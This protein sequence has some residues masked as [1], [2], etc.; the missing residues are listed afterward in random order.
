M[1]S[2]RKLCFLLACPFLFLS[3]LKPVE[4]GR[5][6]LFVPAKLGQVRVFHDVDGF[7]V[8]KN[9][10]ISDIQNCFVDKEIRNIS[11]EDLAFALGLKA[12]IEIGGEEQIFTRIPAELI[13]KLIVEN[14]DFV[15]LSQEDSE[16]IIA[17]L[18]ASGYLHVFQFSDG[19]Y[20]LHF[21]TRL[22]GGGICGG[23]AGALF[24]KG[25]VHVIG[26]GSIY[27]VCRGIDIFLPGAGVAAQIAITAIAAPMIEAAS[28]KAA[29]VGGIAAMVATGPI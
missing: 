7:K 24:S 26:H 3:L 18:P 21:R 12:K 17:Q 15:Q 4:I 5:S 2:K 16:K 25:A 27:L 28:I 23:I 22:P 9:G 20:G 13:N 6:N 14:E 11:D 8:M 10:E 19:E 29:M 1:I